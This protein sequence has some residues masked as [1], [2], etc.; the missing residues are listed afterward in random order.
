MKNEFSGENQISTQK[1][2]FVVKN[3]ETYILPTISIDVQKITKTPN[4]GRKLAY[5]KGFLHQKHNFTTIKGFSS[6][7]RSVRSKMNFLATNGS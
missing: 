7:K 1:M 4:F 2:D 6:K 5:F 3:G